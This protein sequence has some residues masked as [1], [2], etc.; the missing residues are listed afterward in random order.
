[1]LNSK[2]RARGQTSAVEVAL[3]VPFIIMAIIIFLTLAPN[4]SYSAG[5]EVNT[6]QL[7]AMAQSL[8]QYIVT[9]PGNPPDWG[10]NASQMT[11]FGLALPNQPYHLDPFKVLALAYWDYANGI[12]SMKELNGYCTLSQI[13]GSG[14]RSYLSQSGISAISIT[15]NWLFMPGSYTPWL[16]SYDEVKKM[17][18]LSGDYE[19]KLVITP[20][21]NIS[22][23]DF[24]PGPGS[25]NLVVRVADY[26]STT[27]LAGA[28]GTLRY[29]MADHAGTD[30]AGQ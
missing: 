25:F 12:V 11:A 9:N 2:S 23:I 6:F 5:S 24:P 22:V 27:P 29:F 8:L 1:M 14:F 28:K 19:F 13:S 20:V 21:M 30:L 17:L 16:I 7:N 15:S 26:M 18:G 10:L 4:Y 3:I